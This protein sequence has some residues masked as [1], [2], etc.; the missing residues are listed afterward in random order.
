MH[1]NEGWTEDQAEQAL[2]ALV[3]ESKLLEIEP[4]KFAMVAPPPPTPTTSAS[5]KGIEEKKP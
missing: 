3:E 5:K 2:Y 1:P 4:D